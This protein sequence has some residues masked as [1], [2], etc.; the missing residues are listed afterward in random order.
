MQK[1]ILAVAAILKSFVD[2]EAFCKTVQRSYRV[3][4]RS[5][6]ISSGYQ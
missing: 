5:N 4:V 2:I 1:E 6:A 3:N